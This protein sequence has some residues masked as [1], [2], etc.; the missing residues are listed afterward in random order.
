MIS[1]KRI[2]FA[3]IGVIIGVGVWAM[4]RIVVIH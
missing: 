2:A 4:F 3:I 1:S